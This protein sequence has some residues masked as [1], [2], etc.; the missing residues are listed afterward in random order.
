MKKKDLKETIK[1]T[2]GALHKEYKDH[3]SVEKAEKWW[4]SK[5]KMFQI[6]LVITGVM[7]LWNVVFGM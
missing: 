7:I 6:I 3:E 4:K 1:D 5:S 2:A